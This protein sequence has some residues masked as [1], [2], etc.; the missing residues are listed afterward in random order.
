MAGKLLWL[1]LAGAA[2]A[3][4]LRR[5]RRPR[6]LGEQD[7]ALVGA[8]AA[9][10]EAQLQWCEAAS[11]VPADAAFLHAL[12]RTR[13][14]AE[15]LMAEPAHLGARFRPYGAQIRERLGVH[16]AADF[17]G[18]ADAHGSLVRLQQHSLVWL[19][20]LEPLAWDPAVR[21]LFARTRA[22]VAGCR[23][24]A[25]ELLRRASGLPEARHARPQDTGN[26]ES[27]LDE[28]LEETFPCSDPV[29]PFIPARAP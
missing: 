11:R 29:S 25:L 1:A 4:V 26:R 21:R 8:I 18:L 27:L 17:P 13:R 15:R 7:R 22:Q 19:N 9:V 14:G 12:R 2:S 28:G 24:E 20:D 23:D 6:R 10:L 16:S 5:R 3:I